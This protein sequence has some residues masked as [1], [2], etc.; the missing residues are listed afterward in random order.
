MRVHGN[1]CGPGWSG[2][3]YQSSVVSDVEPVDEFDMTCKVHD[4]VYAT[5]GDLKQADYDFFQANFGKSALRSLAGLAVGVQGALR[6]PD[7]VSQKAKNMTKSKLRGSAQNPKNQNSKPRSAN[8]A[9]STVAAPATI[10][11]VARGS[12]PKF[13]GNGSIVRVGHRSLISTIST[14]ASGFSINKWPINPGLAQTFPWLSKLGS[15]YD[16]Y[17]FVSLRFEYKSVCPT[18][19]SGVMMMSVDFDAADATPTSKVDQAQTVPNVESNVWLGAT[20]NVPVD[21]T[22]RFTRQGLVS[23]TDIKTYDLGNLFVS[24]IYGSGITTGELY[25][26][27][28]VELTKPTARSPLTSTVISTAYASN[29][30]FLASTTTYGGSAPVVAGLSNSLLQFTVSG[31]FQVAMTLTGTGVSSLNEPTLAATGAGVKKLLWYTSPSTT[32]A[33]RIIACRIDAGDTLDFSGAVSATTVT[34]LTIRVTE[35]EYAAL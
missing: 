3:K 22:W 8:A 28:V 12:T 31:E 21:N 18:S 4:H 23:N 9:R 34:N 33:T 10:G 15:R 32:S 14:T 20:L 13:N 30:Q 27:Y 2:G 1:Y 24:T 17:R 29:P 16:K 35:G 7:F 26:E 19:T 25:V 6:P 11:T 5:D